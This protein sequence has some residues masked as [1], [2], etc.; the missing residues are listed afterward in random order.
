MRETGISTSAQTFVATKHNTNLVS[1]R[2]GGHSYDLD[3]R[4]RDWHFDSTVIATVEE[5]E[6]FA[7]KLAI[8][9]KEAKEANIARELAKLEDGEVKAGK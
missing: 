5:A 4:S 1:W 8:A 7:D 9:I 2:V 3:D 6:A